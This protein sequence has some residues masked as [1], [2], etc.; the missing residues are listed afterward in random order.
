[1]QSF[2][3]Q[4]RVLMM[5]R[6][7]VKTMAAVE[8]V[9]QAILKK[10][11]DIIIGT[12]MV[13]KGHHF[14]AL[15]LVGIVDADLGLAGGDLRAAER[16]YQLLHQVSGRAGREHLKGRVILQSYMPDNSIIQA[17]VGSA[18]DSFI[19]SEIES[20]R[21]NAMPP[22]SRLAALVVSG[23]NEQLTLQVAK[24]LARTA[25]VVQGVEVLGP[26]PAVLYQL[27]KKFRYRLLMKTERS[28]HIQKL[29][30]HWLDQSTVPA[31][32]QV[33]VVIDPYSFF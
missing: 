3:P 13:A 15:T 19:D 26:A 4:A 21:E 23:E 33:R 7:T 14:P 32:V 2:L 18:R 1:V 6:D 17:L 29:V 11:V 27:R 12:Q 22:F 9:I 31:S 30:R 8:G 28:I 20:R 25:P 24:H 5:T 16:T 10:E